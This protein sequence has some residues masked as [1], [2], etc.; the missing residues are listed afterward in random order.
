MIYF[1]AGRYFQLPEDYFFYRGSC[2]PP[3]LKEGLHKQVGVALASG[4]AEDA[5]KFHKKLLEVMSNNME[6]HRAM[7]R[8]EAFKFKDSRF[9]HIIGLC[10]QHAW[11]R[12]GQGGVSSMQL[13]LSQ[14]SVSTHGIS[15]NP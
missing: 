11:G 8:R 7:S 5:E 13:L 6:N 9:S 15:D 1:Q 4:T 10:E 14:V 3:A 2:L 12:E